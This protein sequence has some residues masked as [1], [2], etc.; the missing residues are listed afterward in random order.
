MRNLETNARVSKTFKKCI[1]KTVCLVNQYSKFYFPINLLFM[2]IQGFIPALLLIIMKNTINLIQRNDGDFTE[3]SRL[4]LLY[5]GLNILNSLLSW[6]YS[7]YSAQFN[8]RFSKYINVKM[9]DKAAN[10]QVSD[11]ED[12]STY[13]IINR[14]QTQN[15]NSILCYISE[16]FL[17]LK[18]LVTIGST[19]LVLLKFNW[20]III[21]ILLV[22]IV[23][24][25]VTIIIDKNWYVIRKERTS[26]ERK[27]WYINYLM[28]M[29]IAAKEIKIF[30]LSQYLIEKYKTI[31]KNI[32]NQDLRMQKKAS[33]V[34]FV[35][36]ICDWIITGFIYI[37]TVFQGFFGILMIGD[38]TACISGIDKIKNS[39]DSVFS[40]IE[41]IMEQSL[42]IDF[43]FQYLEIPVKIKRGE[44]KVSHIK[45]IELVNV[46]YKY[47]DNNYAIKNINMVLENYSH[48]ALIGTNGSGKT[49]LIKLIMGLY[50]DYEGEIFI[51]NINMKEI[52]IEEYQR[53]VSCIFQDYV[54]YEMPI[55]ENIGFGDVQNILNDKAV[56][57]QIE[58]V[59]LKNKISETDSLEINLGNWFGGIELSGGEWQRIAIA[60]M[61]MK[62][63]ELFI[64]D[65]PDASLDA[66]KQKEMIKIYEQEMQGNISVYISHKV[67]YV[68]LIADCIYV[69]ANGEIVEFGGHE[70]LF[71]R[72]GVYYQLV[73][74]CNKKV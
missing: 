48:I 62:N 36:D 31:T 12:A 21:L 4:L 42:Y 65:E 54:K 60:R 14:A 20:W 9:L 50:E 64:L 15:G 67:D 19:G 66:L 43:L 1:H 40:G 55:R 72:K 56:R 46:S 69:L 13:D 24:C 33:I 11:F 8:M 49:T 45:K 16:N 59:H 74:E 26:K 5:I 23:R 2:I 41:N 57:E 68:N 34:E 47:D 10:L 35:L 32:I 3:I 58:K 7:Y 17:V 29:G 38:V 53:K 73:N 44:I 70:Q 28:M 61:L 39:A 6:W 27:K 51:N 63:A 30:A 71:S 52:D 22:P 37:Y 25:I 18:A